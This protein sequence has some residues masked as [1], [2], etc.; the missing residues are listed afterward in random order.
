MGKIAFVF[1]G[2]GAQYVGMGKELYDNFE[3]AKEI[4]EK[5]QAIRPNTKE[6]C[7]EGTQQELNDTIN[8]QPCLFCVDLACAKVLNENGIYAEGVSGFSLGEIPA[9]CYSE[10]MDF[11]SAF[12]FVIKRA[13]YMNNCAKANPGSMAAVL[14]LSNEQVETLCEELENVYPVNYN[15]DGQV[16]VAGANEQMEQ[17]IQ[18]VPQAGGKA[19]KLAVSGAFHSPF[20]NNASDEVSTY[21]E[22]KQLHTPKLPT[23]SNVTAQLYSEN[24]K[25]LISKQIKSPVKWQQTIINMINDGFDTFIEVGAGKTLS[26]LIKKTSNEVRIYNVENLASLEKTISELNGGENA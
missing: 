12:S 15:C 4:F 20:M 18:K 24:A 25:E 11:D 23:Y 14:K 3:S 17:F 2:Q 22:D 13:E 21:L 6:Q 16:V 8:T 5:A 1:A 9:L 26:G 10:V 7:F 19:I